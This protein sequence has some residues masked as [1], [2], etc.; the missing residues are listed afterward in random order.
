[1]NAVRAWQQRYHYQDVR[2][3]ALLGASR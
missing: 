3:D 1:L 2:L